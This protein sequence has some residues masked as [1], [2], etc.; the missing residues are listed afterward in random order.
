MPEL[1]ILGDCPVEFWCRG[2]FTPD[3]LFR[4]RIGG[5]SFQLARATARRGFDTALISRLGD[6]LFEPYIRGELQ[7]AGLATSR[8]LTTPGANGIIFSHGDRSNLKR[9]SRRAPSASAGL[10]LLDPDVALIEGSRWFCSAADFQALSVTAQDCVYAGFRTA[11][12]GGVRTAFVTNFDPRLREPAASRAALVEIAPLVEVAFIDPEQAAP[13]QGT[14]DPCR[15]AAWVVEQGIRI[16]VARAG[17]TIM[18]VATSATVTAVTQEEPGAPERDNADAEASFLS[19]LAGGADPVSAARRARPAGADAATKAGN[20]ASPPGG[21]AHCPSSAV[22][23]IDGGSRGNPGVAGAGVYFEV[24]GQPWRGLYQYLGTQTNNF[25]EYSALLRALSY[26]LEHG[27]SAPL[28]LFGFRTPRSPAERDLPRQEPRASE[29]PCRSGTAHQPPGAVFHPPCAARTEQKSRRPCEPGA[30][31]T[32]QRRR[33]VSLRARFPIWYPKLMSRIIPL[34]L[35]A[36]AGLSG[37]TALP[38]EPAT[39]LSIVFDGNKTVDAARLKSNLRFCREGALFQPAALDSDIRRLGAFYEDSGYLR[40][41]DRASAVRSMMSPARAGGRDPHPCG[42]R[43]AVRTGRGCR[44][45]RAGTQSRVPAADAS[46]QAGAAVQPR[47]DVRV[48]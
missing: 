43:A 11:F 20:D 9:S 41:R 7:R 3:T 21:K 6:D 2:P 40:A 42:R 15:V 22:A 25:A 38:A 18:A 5:D 28:G 17:G 14:D 23:Y 24:D 33:V 32:G 8:C 4:S 46:A 10:T 48:A 36:L 45:E 29:A 35:L 16:A 19:A 44:Q 1:A 47:P 26:S 37:A 30:G 13:W 12:D 39:V 31:R 27:P 34:F